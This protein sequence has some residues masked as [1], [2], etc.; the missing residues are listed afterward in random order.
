MLVEAA[1]GQMPAADGADQSGQR[2]E[3]GL[4]ASGKG[5]AVST[6]NVATPAAA[7]SP[8]PIKRDTVITRAPKP[9][10]PPG[11]ARSV[12]AAQSCV[13]GQ[14]AP[15]LYP[16]WTG[17]AVVPLQGPLPASHKSHHTPVTYEF[18]R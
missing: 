13:P 3:G 7:S 9:A 12:R 2:A 5:C 1:D 4:K 16:L 8:V 14:P 18:C 10:R 11:S 17:S 6:A 15:R